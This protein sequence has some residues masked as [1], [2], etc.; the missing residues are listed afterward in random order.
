[1]ETQKI[2]AQHLASQKAYLYFS[3]NTFQSH[4][5]E[6]GDFLSIGRHPTNKLCLD[7]PHI[8]GQHARIERHPRGYFFLRDLCSKNG[9]VLNGNHIK[10]AILNDGDSIQLGQLQF[11]L[12]YKKINSD[13]L[14]SYSKPWQKQLDRIPLIAK[15]DCAVLLLGESGT[16]KDELA[17]KVHELSTRSEGPFISVNC[18]ALSENL[19]ESELFGHIKGSFTG[20]L[21]D[22][23]GAFEAAKGGTLFLD[24]IGDLPISLQ[25]KLLR[26]LENSEIKDSMVKYSPNVEVL[27][28]IDLSD[29]SIP[30]EIMERIP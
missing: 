4:F 18:S 25:P 20:A 11:R 14:R 17:R 21:N 10:E 29:N 24:E 5:Y 3:E 1:M 6:I 9:S 12:H 15:S 19:I 7:D 13:F 27:L 30:E 22:R 2:S 23:Q 26:A 8:S 28:P 16:G